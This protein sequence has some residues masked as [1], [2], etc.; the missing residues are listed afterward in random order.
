MA[1]QESVQQEALDAGQGPDLEGQTLHTAFRKVYV[2]R[3]L[4]DLVARGACA[5]AVLLALIPL[6]G[7]LGYVVVRGAPALSGGFLTGLPAPVGETGGG[8]G[9]AIEGTLILVALGASI[10]VPLGILVGVYL[11]EYGQTRLGR[12]VR[13]SAD[14]LSGTPSIVIGIFA[15]TVM[16]LP[17]KRFSTLAGGFALA[18]LMIPTITRAT[19]EMLKLVPESLREA[20]LA[21][22]VPRWKATLRIV[23]RTAA[24]GITTGVMLAVARA[25]GETAP[26]LF[27]AFGSRYWFEGLGEPVSSLPQQIFLFAVSPYEDWKTQAWGAA[28]VLVMLVLVLNWVARFLVRVRS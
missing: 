3:R 9:N 11:A 2:W 25:A 22:G 12:L 28:L 8:I 19:E 17:F 1:G 23:V 20:A 27:T 15:Y 21:L 13:F 26:L 24:P 18:V 16:V 7:V 5:L 10:S 6:L 14:T 4:Q